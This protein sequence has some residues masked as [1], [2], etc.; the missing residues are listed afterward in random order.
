[1]L[2]AP[3]PQETL[4]GMV[5]NGRNFIFIKLDR[6]HQPLYAPS[7]ELIVDRA[8]DLEKTL[9]ILKRLAGIAASTDSWNITAP[10][11]PGSAIDSS[12]P[13]AAQN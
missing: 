2:A 6:H 1:M 12:S 5:T 11:P 9:Q 7:E 10:S 3:T 4:Y 13:S 8:N